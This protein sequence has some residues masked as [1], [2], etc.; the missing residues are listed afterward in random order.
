[1]LLNEDLVYDCF[2]GAFLPAAALVWL[3]YEENRWAIAALL[4]VAI[5]LN[6]AMFCGY[7]VNHIDISPR[8][9][10]LLFGISNGIGQ[11]LAI[12]AP[13]L[14]QFIVYEEVSSSTQ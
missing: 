8:F 3:A 10:G 12:L 7:N 14:V 13:M 1:M 5:T 6:G 4:I 11:T 2:L 9:S